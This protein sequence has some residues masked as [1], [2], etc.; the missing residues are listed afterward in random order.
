MSAGAASHLE[1]KKGPTVL[2]IMD[3]LGN[4]PHN[5]WN[6]VTN[7][8]APFLKAMIGDAQKQGRYAALRTDGAFVGL[9]D[10]QMGNSEVGHST[11]GSGRITEKPYT[12]IQNRLKDQSLFDAEGVKTLLAQLQESGGTLHLFGLVSD[13]G[14][15]SHIDHIVGLAKYFD[16]QGVPVKIHA[17]LDGRDVAPESAMQ[18]L[19]QL[20]D[21]LATCERTTLA[22]LSGRSFSMDRNGQWANL[23]MAYDAI[24]FGKGVEG[25]A[26]I[27]EDKIEGYLKAEHARQ[28]EA[29]T[30]PSDELVRPI[31]MEGYTGMD[32][33]DGLL[34][35]NF[36]TD[37]AKEISE[38]LVD[39]VGLTQRLIVEEAAKAA[40]KNRPVEE[41]VK[42]DQKFTQ[43]GDKQFAKDNALGMTEYSD[44]HAKIMQ[45]VLVVPKEEKAKN[46][47]AEVIS[48]AGKSQFHI[49]ETE[50]YAHV[51]R[52]LDDRDE[53]FEGEQVVKIESPTLPPGGTYAQCPA[54]S[55]AEV[56]A[57]LKEAIASG[58]HDFIVVNYAQ[59]DMVGHTGDFDAAKGSVEAMDT[60]LKELIPLIK[61]QNGTALVIADHG[62]VEQMRAED[63]VTPHT[64]HTTNPVHMMLVGGKK[65]LALP[66]AGKEVGLADVAPT[67][68]DLMEL[69]KPKEMTGQSQISKVKQLTGAGG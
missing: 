47:L 10:G 46:V 65:T 58:K 31:V 64:K 28:R 38:A 20:K 39:P 45:S 55:S 4:G 13:G 67:I 1:A 44:K 21:E 26:P 35:A 32:A 8:N 53:Q 37:R 50:K 17:A 15:H 11:I 51:T 40:E 33:K 42:F 48:K 18:Y 66:E 14:V 56:T 6:A 36:R 49:A 62:N 25:N 9:P 52:F 16:R 57:K 30:S 7:A 59:P 24:T 43:E 19:N 2:I 5:E 41:T 3:G 22:T 69:E 23:K 54:M 34:V 60:A 61:R 12:T 68:L 27:T 63:G 29:G